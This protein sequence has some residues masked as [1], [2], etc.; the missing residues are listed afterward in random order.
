[1]RISNCSQQATRLTLECLIPSLR[2][3]RKAVGIWDEALSLL[4]L[5]PVSPKPAPK[6]VWSPGMKRLCSVPPLS[7]P[8]NPTSSTHLDDTHTRWWWSWWLALPACC[9]CAP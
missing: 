5:L 3:R 9:C 2:V 1:M 4:S 6:P 7:F 8:S